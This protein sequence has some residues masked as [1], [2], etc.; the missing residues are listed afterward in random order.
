M[1]KFFFLFIV[2]QEKE[3]EEKRLEKRRP[4]LED[5]PRRSKTFYI[6]DAECFPQLFRPRSSQRDPGRDKRLVD[7]GVAAVSGVKVLVAARGCESKTE[8]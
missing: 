2:R 6:D 1:E 3:E 5:D 4:T 7:V 8:R